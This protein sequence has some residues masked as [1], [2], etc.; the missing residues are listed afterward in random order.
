MK[1]SAGQI[2]EMPYSG[3]EVSMLIFL[4]AEIEDD[5]TG[6]EK[7]E[8]LH[9][10]DVP[11]DSFLSQLNEENKSDWLKTDKHPDIKSHLKTPWRQK[12]CIQSDL[13]LLMTFLN[14]SCC[15]IVQDVTSHIYTR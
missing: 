14:E 7:V 12:L 5:T 1:P 9:T 10:R 15:L 11:G 6:L 2:L 13:K 8:H 3:E 4:P